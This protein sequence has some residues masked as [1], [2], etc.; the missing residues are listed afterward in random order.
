MTGRFVSTKRYGH[1]VGLSCCFRQPKADHSHCSKLHGYALAFRFEFSA[2]LDDRNWVM[3]FGGLKPLKQA[4]E[5]WFDHTIAVDLNDPAIDDLCHLQHIGV[6]D[7]RIFE[8]GVG[9]ERFAEFAA[10][11]AQQELKKAGLHRRV[12]VLSVECAEH[13]ANS[14]IFYPDN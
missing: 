13:G 14:A 11:L 12:R 3:D 4:L 8:K 7:V 6:A 10:E 5:L 9:C 1:E 2:Q